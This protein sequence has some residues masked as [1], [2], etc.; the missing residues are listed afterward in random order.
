[1]IRFFM[2]MTFFFNSIHVGEIEKNTEDNISKK[3]WKTKMIPRKT[4]GKWGV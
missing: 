1:V 4:H 3:K 2:Q